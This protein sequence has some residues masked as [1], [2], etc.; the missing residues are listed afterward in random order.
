MRY[1]RLAI[2][3]LVVFMCLTLGLLPALAQELNIQDMKKP[4][5]ASAQR[6]MS[7]KILIEGSP[8]WADMMEQLCQV[9]DVIKIANQAGYN[10][11]CLPGMCLREG[12]F[13]TQLTVLQMDDTPVKETPKAVL[14]KMSDHLQRFLNTV[15]GPRQDEIKE[16]EAAAK[17]VRESEREVTRL[18]EYL[19]EL[20]RHMLRQG[21]G[22]SLEGLSHQRRELQN[23]RSMF[24]VELAGLRAR[25]EA[26][27]KH[28]ATQDK[29]VAAEARD[30]QRKLEELKLKKLEVQ[31]AYKDRERQLLESR[32]NQGTGPLSDLERA[33]LT[34]AEL[35]LDIEW[36]Q[37]VLRGLAAK[38]KTQPYRQRTQPDAEL[39]YLES[40][41]KV[42]E[43]DLKRMRELVK[44][45][46]GTIPLRDVEQAELELIKLQCSLEDRRRDNER[47]PRNE[48]LTGLT[49]Q[50]ADIEIETA[51]IEAKC[52]AIDKMLNKL[53]LEK[54]QN[55]AEEIEVVE[56]RLEETLDRRAAAREQLAKLERQQEGLQPPKVTVL[57]DVSME[58]LSLDKK[59]PEKKAGRKN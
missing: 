35:K 4:D 56:G 12:R 38:N 30:S 50:L 17:R 48:F 59:K 2:L 31:L 37:E 45:A 34:V 40:A 9:S 6:P 19:T 23:Q 58:K 22:N 51:T 14:K 42:Q 57:D 46:P 16:R 10:A 26:I 44:K 11:E 24:Q 39:K 8:N 41:I 33:R 1:P 47:E 43:K 27:V 36:Q 29:Q 15:A 49:H 28:I 55:I 18:R 54:L 53:N 3:F 7:V 20:K 52:V 25:R 32:Y 13:I 5:T 21:G